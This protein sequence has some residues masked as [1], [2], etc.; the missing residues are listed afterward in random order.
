MMEIWDDV[1]VAC[2]EELWAP[3]LQRV[4][5]GFAL[6][7]SFQPDQSMEGNR[8]RMIL[9]AGQA[10]FRCQ[11]WSAHD[12]STEVSFWELDI[13]NDT[14]PKTNIDPEVLAPWKIVF[15]GSMGSSSRVY[16]FFFR[17]SWWVSQLVAPLH[18]L[19]CWK[20]TCI[21]RYALDGEIELHEMSLF[22]YPR[23]PKTNYSLTDWSKG[24]SFS[25]YLKTILFTV[26]DY[27]GI[28]VYRL[29]SHD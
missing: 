9:R 11:V 14:L 29:S 19:Q 15:W 8:I 24:N 3:T 4:C 26:F 1:E 27:Q 2:H 5:V 25:G 16:L 20:M 22:I 28:Y 18:G 17:P 23:S 13:G 10:R 6:L 21:I 7:L 12:E